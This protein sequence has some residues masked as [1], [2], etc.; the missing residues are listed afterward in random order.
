MRN[1]VLTSKIHSIKNW[2]ISV[3]LTKNLYNT[4]LYR[5]RQQYFTEHTYLNYKKIQKDLQNENNP[6]Y[7]ALPAKVAQQTLKLLDKNFM[8]YFALL[9]LKKKGKYDKPVH[10]PGYYHKKRGRSVVC[11]TSQAIS[12]DETAGTVKLSKTNIT[13]PTKREKI[14]FA[15]IV[16]RGYKIVVEIGYQEK[17]H[18]IY[19]ETQPLKFSAVDLGLDN[20]ATVTFEAEKPVIINGRPL[21]SVN[22]QYNKEK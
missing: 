5:V 21:K 15:R 17:C 19:P 10:V 1:T 13:I 12:H 18:P 3:F 14:Q 6:D 8:S 4:A 2:I 9:K 11:Y 22:Q 7:R 16:H 20:L